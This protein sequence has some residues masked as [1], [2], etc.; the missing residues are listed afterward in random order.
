MRPG[1][2][3]PPHHRRR[4]GC[5]CISAQSQHPKRRTRIRRWVSYYVTDSS[6]QHWRHATTFVLPANT[7]VHVTVYQ[8][9]GQSG[10]RNPFI[11]Q[12]RGTVGRTS[13]WTASR[14]RR[15]T[16]T[17]PRTC[18]RSRRSALGPSGGHRR[19]RQEPVRQRAVLA[20]PGPPHDRVHVPHA[21]PGPVPLAVLRSLRR[22]LHQ[23]L[24]RPDADDRV[25]G[26]LPQGRMRRNR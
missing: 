1:P 2:P 3:R 7:L 10:M 5:I 9:D 22:R 17:P 8:F 19:R 21:T 15:S 23:R 18:S 4:P 26:R 11:S 25:H 20:E 14:P 13:R 16:R 24:R 12:A 6:D